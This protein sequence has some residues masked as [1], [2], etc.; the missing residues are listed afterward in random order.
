MLHS[1]HDSIPWVIIAGGRDFDDYGLLKKKCSHI[2]INLPKAVI[3]SRGAKGADTLGETFAASKNFSV[4]RFRA[5]WTLYGKR[6]G[7]IRNT[8]M[9]VNSDAL[10]AFWDGKS[11]GTKH[12]IEEAKRLGLPTRVV[13]Y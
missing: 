8:E 12:M 2:L 3:V 1:K 5:D 11:S 13:R 7:I 4:I 6:A 9:A 10:I